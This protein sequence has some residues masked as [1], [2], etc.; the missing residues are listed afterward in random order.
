MPRIY[1]TG[2]LIEPDGSDTDPNGEPTE[3]G[4]GSTMTD[5]WIDPSW[6]RWTVYDDRDDVAADV[7]EP[8]DGPMI[9]WLIDTLIMR[10]SWIETHDM[11]E[12]LY[13]T[14]PDEDIEDGRSMSMAAHMHDVPPAI[15]TA[16][17]HGI[18]NRQRRRTH[19][20]ERPSA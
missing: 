10:L 12:T 6:S 13:A 5:G 9:D 14:E 18:R 8:A 20:P 3:P 17:L 11:N 15:V 19:Q 1:Y 2:T 7:W 16:V 4:Y